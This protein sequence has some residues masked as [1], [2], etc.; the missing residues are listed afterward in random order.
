MSA[1]LDSG[2]TL[3]FI[4]ERLASTLRL[5]TQSCSSVQVSL[6]DGRILTHATRFLNL[7]LSIA[8]LPQSHTFL[9]AP[10]GIH[11]MIL[12]MA[13][14]ETVNPDIDWKLKSVKSC[15]DTTLEPAAPTLSQ[16]HPNP[17]PH[18]KPKHRKR[19]IP[20]IRDL[21]NCPLCLLSTLPDVFIPMIK[22]I[23]L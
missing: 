8:G 10:I 17:P 12:S 11:S 4:N 15:L 21:A 16:S 18:L 3:N 6:A 23:F 22:S 9:L 1:L 20:P 2:A 14:L 19:N 13:W 7:P 5:P